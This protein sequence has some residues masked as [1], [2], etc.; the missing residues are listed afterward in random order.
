L[1]KINSFGILIASIVFSF[2]ILNKL[3]SG[4][5]LTSIRNLFISML[6]RIPLNFLGVKIDKKIDKINNE[7]EIIKSIKRIYPEFN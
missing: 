6:P 3:P 4:S 2:L 7:E 5:L 1:K